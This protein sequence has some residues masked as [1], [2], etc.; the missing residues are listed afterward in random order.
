MTSLELINVFL[1]PH[2]MQ[3][4]WPR[5]QIQLDTAEESQ[6]KIKRRKKAQTS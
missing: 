2:E 5:T 6:K 1:V 4:F 3:L